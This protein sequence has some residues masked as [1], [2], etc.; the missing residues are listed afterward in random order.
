MGP[1]FNGVVDW[2]RRVICIRRPNASMGPRF[3]GVEDNG[4]TC[5][6]S[7]DRSH[8]SMGPRFNGVEDIDVLEG[9]TQDRSGF[10]GATL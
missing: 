8:A 7:H 9:R 2:L 1:R 3:N 6:R 5:H 4:T 10:N